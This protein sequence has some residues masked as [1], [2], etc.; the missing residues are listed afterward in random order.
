MGFDADYISDAAEIAAK[1]H[2]ALEARYGVGE[3][4]VEDFVHPYVYLNRAEIASRELDLD[5]VAQVVA[6][7]LERQPGIAR[8]F[9]S[10]AIRSG[11]YPD[12]R[13]AR[14][15]LHN[16]HPARSGDVYVVARPDHFV[17]DFDGLTV[18][19]SHGSPWRYDTYV[20]VIFLGPGIE[21]MV[22]HREVFTVDVAATLAA[23]VGTKPPSGCEGEP[24][25]ELFR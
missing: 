13:V 24:L 11:E 10:E 7:T 17:N 15:V 21:A 1:V 19:A 6:A 12:T 3:V 20:P 25:V 16:Y 2:A 23:L 5:E 4:L 22:V 18:A 8:A 9:T 14:A